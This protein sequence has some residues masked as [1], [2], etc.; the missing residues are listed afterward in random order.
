MEK[1]TGLEANKLKATQTKNQTNSK[2]FWMV[3]WQTELK[4]LRQDTKVMK[5]HFSK[6]NTKTA[7]LV[8]PPLQECY[9][10]LVK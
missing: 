8:A 10:T 2:G 5:L 7:K 1:N 3:T 9:Q 4:A 6:G